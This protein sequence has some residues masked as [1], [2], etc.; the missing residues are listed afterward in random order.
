M[1]ALTVTSKGQVTFRKDILQH[2][3]I[4]P[5]QKI[6]LNKL[7]GGQINLRAAQPRRGIDGFVGLLQGKSK[8]VAS[9]EEIDQAISESWSCKV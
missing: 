2:L 3:G 7:P 5:G 9:L 4:H 6:E 8:K 1:T